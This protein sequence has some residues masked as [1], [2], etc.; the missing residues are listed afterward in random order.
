MQGD[1]H[2]TV[3]GIP[4]KSFYNK[5]DLDLARIMHE[6]E[7]PGKYPFTRGIFPQGY[8][9]QPWMES[10]SSG[11]GQPEETNQREKYLTSAGQAG[12]EDRASINLVFDRPTFCGLDSDY[13]LAANEVGQVG[14]CIDSL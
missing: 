5:D 6:A 4:Q 1:S 8:R 12:Y 14:V 10:L 3:S 13:A 9:V 11:Y 2:P 7:E